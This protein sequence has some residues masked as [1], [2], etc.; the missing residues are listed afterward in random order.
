[1]ANKKLDLGLTRYSGNRFDDLHKAGCGCITASNVPDLFG[2]GRNGKLALAGHVLGLL[3]F[4]NKESAVMKRGK[5]MQ[6]LIGSWF[7]EETGRKTKVIHAWR[8]HPELDYYVSPDALIDVDKDVVTPA[9]MKVVAAPVYDMDWEMGPPERVLVQHQAQMHITGAES[10]PVIALKIGDFSYD[11]NHWNVPANDLMGRLIEDECKAF[12]EL[13]ANRTLPPP[14]LGNPSDQDALVRLARMTEGTT[15]ELPDECGFLIRRY[16]RTGLLKSRADKAQKEAKA[17]LIDA[18][19]G[20]EVGY[21]GDKRVLFAVTQMKGHP[22]PPH[23]RRAIYIK[24]NNRD[25]EPNVSKNA[26]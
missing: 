10:G 14:D 21:C 5:M 11:I 16:Q 7:E 24:K 25:D 19:D 22:I 8:K 13:I 20:A 2:V 12:L 17:R 23:E 15:I 3:P 1:M 26:V 4:K 9:E 18:L 6:P